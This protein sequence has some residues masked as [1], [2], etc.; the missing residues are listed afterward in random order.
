MAVATAA[1]G[2]KKQQLGLM[3]EEG[4]GKEVAV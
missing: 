4:Q 2:V 1:A 3:A